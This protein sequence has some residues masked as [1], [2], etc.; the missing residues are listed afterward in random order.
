MRIIFIF[1]TFYRVLFVR[2]NSNYQFHITQENKF[3]SAISNIIVV[4]GAFQVIRIYCQI[5]DVANDTV[6]HR[7]ILNNYYM[8]LGFSPLITISNVTWTASWRFDVGD[9]MWE[10][11]IPTFYIAP[12]LAHQE[13]QL[14]VRLDADMEAH[15]SNGSLILSYIINLFT[16]FERV[17]NDELVKAIGDYEYVKKFELYPV[18]CFPDAAIA[19][20]ITNKQ[21]LMSL[22]FDAFLSPY[23]TKT[24][25]LESLQRL[26]SKSYE[27]EELNHILTSTK[28]TILHTRNKLIIHPHSDNLQMNKVLSLEG[29]AK[30]FDNIHTLHAFS[31]NPFQFE[32]A[33]DQMIEDVLF[34]WVRNEKPVLYYTYPPFAEMRKRNFSEPDSEIIQV[35]CSRP[36]YP[37]FT[38]PERFKVYGICV[39]K[40]TMIL[41]AY[42]NELWIS[43][44]SGNNWIEMF[45]FLKPHNFF[46]DCLTGFDDDLFV[47]RTRDHNIFMTRIGPDQLV[48]VASIKAS[49]KLMMTL[50][51][52]LL[53]IGIKDMFLTRKESSRKAINIGNTT[54]FPFYNSNILQSRPILWRTTKGIFIEKYFDK[55]YLD[56]ETLSKVEKKYLINFRK[57]FVVFPLSSL[58][59]LLFLFNDTAKPTNTIIGLTSNY[60][61]HNILIKNFGKIFIRKIRL[62]NEIESSPILKPSPYFSTVEIVTTATT[63][64]KTDFDEFSKK[65]D[66]HV[67]VKSKNEYRATFK[68]IDPKIGIETPDV[69]SKFLRLINGCTIFF[70]KNSILIINH[71][72]Y[73]LYKVRKNVIKKNHWRIFCPKHQMVETSLDDCYTVQSTNLVRARADAAV[74]LDV[75]QKIKR[76]LHI[77]SAAYSY[78]QNKMQNLQELSIRHPL[79]FLRLTNIDGVVVSTESKYEKDIHSQNIE[80]NVESVNKITSTAALTAHLKVSN[81]FCP[82]T[83]YLVTIEARCAQS[84]KL[85]FVYPEDGEYVTLND[86]YR[87]PSDLGIKIYETDNV[88][89]GNPEIKMIMPRISRYRRGVYKQCSGKKS[90]KECRCNEE[91][92][93]VDSVKI[94][95]CKRKVFQVA[96]DDTF[97]LKFVMEE[98][99]SK[100]VDINENH[101]LYI[102]DLNRR[103]RFHILAD[104]LPESFQFDNISILE[105]SKRDGIEYILFNPKNAKL[106]FDATGLFHFSVYLLKGFSYCELRTE[107]MVY[108]L[109]SPLPY[110]VPE[111]VMGVTSISLLLFLIL[112]YLWRVRK[113]KG[114][115]M[116]GSKAKGYL[117]SFDLF[118][119]D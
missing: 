86:N 65:H 9:G 53:V 24:F 85:V 45:R 112:Y 97:P 115:I 52:S 75:A 21:I 72:L 6:E 106:S 66:L 83:T 84:K 107:F 79:A 99:Y 8:M 116:E 51:E 64:L 48:H 76:H 93:K 14:D 30:D 41:I 31:C 50:T 109:S 61:G 60:V 15:H 74:E 32:L 95:D 3:D 102:G 27:I 42:G 28:W 96:F 71:K 33:N 49:E 35:E 58:H 36:T 100:S 105:T 63:K 56:R 23:H 1:I 37:K 70:H 17:P 57:K 78:D 114:V 110:P 54:V 59:V 69:R 7:Q 117:Y 108:V 113:T 47:F 92:E 13:Y 104:E 67:D 4:D 88:Y 118:G 2:G 5:Y 18:K 11:N 16:Y 29:I 40:L 12:A 119:K 62:R 68:F 19:V 80:M 25:S 46:V 89:N 44:D 26:L 81:V 55:K 91:L 98:V 82:S 10:L 39:Q 43:H 101:V 111:M 34:I 77:Y 103:T 90:K 22:S 38:F 87:P 20:I 73:G 94:S